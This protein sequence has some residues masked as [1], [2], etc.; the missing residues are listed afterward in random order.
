MGQGFHTNRSQNNNRKCGIRE[1]RRAGR[2][3]NGYDCV[4]RLCLGRRES[5]RTML[6]TNN[7][8]SP[9]G[10]GSWNPLR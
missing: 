6:F 9:S 2:P 7:S 4:F 10:R 5:Q 1:T 8:V 3:A